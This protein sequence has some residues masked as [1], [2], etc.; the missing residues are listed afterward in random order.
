MELEMLQAG[1]LAE[2]MEW[3]EVGRGGGRGSTPEAVWRRWSE[4]E[5]LHDRPMVAVTDVTVEAPDPP[6]YA[7]TSGISHAGV[8]LAVP[9]VK[10][11]VIL[12]GCLPAGMPFT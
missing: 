5:D 2:D 12:S 7:S 10:Y 8:W 3:Q 9:L 4:G 11:H 1:E 6:A